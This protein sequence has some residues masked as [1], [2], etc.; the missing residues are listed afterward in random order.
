MKVEPVIHLARTPSGRVVEILSWDSKE[1]CYEVRDPKTNET[2]GLK[3]IHV[4]RLDYDYLDA[5]LRER[6]E[7][8]DENSAPR[9]IGGMPEGRL[10]FHFDNWRRW[11]KKDEVTVGAPRTAAGCV[12]GGYSQSFD[13]MA[14][15]SDVRCAR[16]MDALVSSLEH[17]ERAA[18][19]HR[20]LYAVFQYGSNPEETRV[21]LSRSM[22]SARLKIGA[23]LVVRG[24]Y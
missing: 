20:Y 12:G 13:D 23:W 18:I 7:R 9:T 24:V 14:D 6:Q 11:M 3:P 16:I 21:L 17:M 19:Y 15:A 2:F 4:L 5:T 10:E 22:Y 8:A 1:F